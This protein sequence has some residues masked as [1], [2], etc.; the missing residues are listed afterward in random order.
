MTTQTFGQAESLK[1]K[2]AYDEW[3]ESIGVPIHEGYYVEDIRKLELGPW[4]ERGCNAAFLKLAGQEGVSEARVT[5]IPAGQ[6]LP[7]LK[8]GFD[9]IVYVLEGGGMSR[10]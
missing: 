5:E 10:L 4:A 3:I 6:T 7:R 2:S 9:E 1:M 8:A